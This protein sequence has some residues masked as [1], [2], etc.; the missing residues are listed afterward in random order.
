MKLRYILLV[1]ISTLMLGAC[2]QLGIEVTTV[3]GTWKSQVTRDGFATLD[4]SGN[5]TFTARL[6]KDSTLV[7]AESGTWKQN[8]DTLYFYNQNFKGKGINKLK[9]EQMSMNTITLT[10]QDEDNTFILNRIYSNPANDYDSHFEE[11]FDLKKGFWWYAW[12]IICFVL[13]LLLLG[14]FITAIYN[15]GRSF[16]KW[17]TNRTHK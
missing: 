9:I 14:I 1:I 12:Q 7:S 4:I 8:G 3:K 15:L 10:M 11:V 16:V 13:G 2:E 17:I 5:E 6:Y